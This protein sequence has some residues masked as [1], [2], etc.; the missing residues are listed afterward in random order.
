MK[1]TGRA[2]DVLPPGDALRKAVR[3]IGERRK[4]EPDI[5]VFRLIDE[6]GRRFDLSPLDSEFLVRNFSGKASDES[7]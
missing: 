2:A 1:E 4:E 7:P 6:A 3:W 5:P